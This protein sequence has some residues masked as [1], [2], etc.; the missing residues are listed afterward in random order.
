MDNLLA[1]LSRNPVFAQLDASGRSLLAGRGITRR[2]RKDE[3][4]ALLGDVWPYFFMV[5]QGC[6]HAVKESAEGRRLIVTA[7]EPGDIL[8]GMAFFLHE[9]T[10]PVTLTAHE[11]CTITLWDR[12]LLVPLFIANGTS[13]WELSCL[14]VDRMQHASDLVDNLAFHT[15]TGRVARMVL[16]RF[17]RSVGTPVARDMTL[18]EMAAMVGTTREVVCRTLYRL[19][20]D[21]IIQITRTEFILTDK[22]ALEGLAA[23]G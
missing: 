5:G 13:L 6:V 16:D 3:I 1:L 23:G 21:E 11:A 20:E 8:W 12:E 18:A 10:M 15:V 9:A 22:D 17:G 2:Y 19:A 14:M 4:I 7:L